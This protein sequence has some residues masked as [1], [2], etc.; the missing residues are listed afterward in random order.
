MEYTITKVKK[1]IID[2]V[3][4]ADKRVKLKA[5]EIT[6]PPDD[7]MGDLTV[8]C[9]G[10]SKILKKVWIYKKSLYLCKAMNAQ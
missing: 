4:K 3:V 9:F 1:E 8:P 2:L 10:L 7:K 5:A 6:A